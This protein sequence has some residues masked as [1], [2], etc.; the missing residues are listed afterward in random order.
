VKWLRRRPDLRDALV[1]AALPQIR[2][3]HTGVTIPAN[4]APLNFF[5]DEG[6]D[7]FFVELSSSV[8]GSIEI[9]SRSPDI[10][11]PHEPWRR[12]L[13]TN[14]GEML[15]IR[16]FVQRSQQWHRYKMITN[17]IAKHDIDAYLA[18]R[19]IDPV[20]QMWR[21]VSIQQRELATYQESTV[22]DGMS[23]AESCVN[24]HSFVNNDPTRMCIG[25]RSRKYG[26]ATLLV[27]RGEAKKVG[28]KFGYTAW[29]P[30]GRLAVYSMNMSWQFFHT[31]GAEVRDV[32]DMDSALAYYVVENESVAKVPGASDKLRLET[33]PAWSPDGRWLYYC[34]APMLWSNT[35]AELPA[36]YMEVRYDLMRVSYDP[37]TGQWGD[38]ET[39]LSAEETEM[40]ILLPRISPDGRFL[41]F[42]MCRYGCFPI[43]QPSSDLYMMDLSTGEYRP[44]DINS[45]FAESWHSWSS[46]SRWIAFSSK[47]QGGL[48]TRCFLSFVDENGV[49]H[50]PF[51]PPQKDAQFYDSFLKTVSVPELINGPVPVSAK[52]LSRVARSDQAVAVDGITGASKPAGASESWQPLRE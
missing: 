52:T 18:Y 41:L 47:R 15:R 7:R 11:I 45:E 3:D 25:M 37:A 1:V 29:H 48:F 8:G 43:Y 4:I 17:Q 27:D 31:A 20:H 49:A 5:I 39:V 21:E 6:G 33:Y 12:L 16:V 2:P 50:K 32:I 46:N 30:S 44:L 36:R 10:V 9:A 13:A 38:P 19:L 51:M 23:F 28:T 40:S 35:D 22:L 34:S 42:C 14:R 26:D 24:C